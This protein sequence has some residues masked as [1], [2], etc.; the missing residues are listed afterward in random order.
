[1]PYSIYFRAE[2]SNAFLFWFGRLLILF[3]H[4]LQ[5]FRDETEAYTMLKH[6]FCSDLDI[7]LDFSFA[8]SSLSRSESRL[9]SHAGLHHYVFVASLHLSSDRPA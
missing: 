1:M 2:K 7:D 9:S 6:F 5:D 3:G 4:L 8:S